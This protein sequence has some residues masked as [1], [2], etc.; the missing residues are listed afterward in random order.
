MSRKHLSNVLIFAVLILS[1]VSGVALRPTAAAP[2]QSQPASAFDSDV[3]RAWFALQLELVT[4]TWGFSPPVAARAFGYTGV[5][6]YEAVVPGMPGY[7]S[8]AGQLNELAALP[9]IEAD[10]EYHWPAAA[11]AALAA[12]TRLLFPTTHAANQGAIENLYAQY[13]DQYQAGTDAATFERSAAYGE[14]VAQAVFEWSMSDGGHEGFRRNFPLDYQPPAA[15][16]LWTPTARAKGNP[17]S[18][19]QPYWGE[20]RP[21]VLTSGAECAPPPAVEYSLDN[22]SAFYAEAQEVYDIVQHI[23]PE[24]LEIARF[25]ADDPFRTS[26][27]AGHWIAI[28]TQVLER[29]GASLDVAAEGYARL[30][31]AV[32]DSFTTCWNAKFVYNLVRPVTYIQAAIDPNWAPVLVT[33]PF[34]EY[35]SG[36]SV[37]SG[38][39]AYVLTS[40][41]GEDYALTDRTHDRWGLAPRSFDSFSEAAEEAALSRI[42]GGIHYRAAVEHGLE[43][44]QCVAEDRKSVV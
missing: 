1:L 23:T 20:N 34:P 21:F 25:W 11:N 8:L 18:A 44:G 26:T 22:G 30:G 14:A 16:G 10:A 5:A 37:V 2:D 15:D 12:I 9:A 42:Y 43:Q 36:H 32:A 40:L 28:L 7:R 33:P 39:S 29:E 3:A 4:H 27:P 38:A 41:F 35:P 31:I 24:Q 17:Q 19:M 6:L 13:A